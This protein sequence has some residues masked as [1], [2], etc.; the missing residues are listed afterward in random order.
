M[1]LPLGPGV[2]REH[3]ASA[4]SPAVAPNPLP[5]TVHTHSDSSS[6]SHTPWVLW[7]RLRKESL[8]GCI[9]G[10]ATQGLAVA[11]TDRNS[12]PASCTKPLLSSLVLWG[13]FPVPPLSFWR[14]GRSQRL[15]FLP[16]SRATAQPSLGGT[17]PPLCFLGALS[18]HPGV[19]GHARGRR[20]MATWGLSISSGYSNLKVLGGPT[21]TP[22]QPFHQM[23][24]LC[25]PAHV[26]F[27]LA[28]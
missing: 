13:P 9:K 15:T 3:T 19:L 25:A 5:C 23:R 28:I 10:H 26:S 7:E 17:E 1:E 4:P 20:E 22:F 21:H 14:D 24:S 16:D 8:F 2:T 6:V 27:Y 11:Q 18:F 12:P